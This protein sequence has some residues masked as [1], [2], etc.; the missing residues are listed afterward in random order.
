MVKFEDI[1]FSLDYATL[2][3]SSYFVELI[4]EDAYVTIVELTNFVE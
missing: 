4:D 3:V 2:S 1:N